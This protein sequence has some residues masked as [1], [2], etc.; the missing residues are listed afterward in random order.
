MNR[1]LAFGLTLLFSTAVL[2]QPGNMGGLQFKLLQVDNNTWGVFVLP[3]ATISPTANTGAGTGQ[4][5]LVV[6]ESFT[7]TNLK[8]YGGSWSQ[9]ARV[10]SPAEAPG[11]SYVSF[12]FV[13]DEPKIRL[14]AF[15]STLLFSFD[16][17]P[18]TSEYI[19]LFDNQNDPFLP[20]NSYNSNPGNDLAII[21]FGHASGVVYYTYDSNL[22]T[23]NTE[24]MAGKAGKTNTKSLVIIE[25]EEE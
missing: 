9:N 13:N 3:M 10:N 11:R 17:T 25:E 22:G 18:E 1:L 4:V 5:T 21:D 23:E 7:F 12:G 15:E 14:F 8:N 16:V 19:Q 6:P 20:P 24:I 2:G